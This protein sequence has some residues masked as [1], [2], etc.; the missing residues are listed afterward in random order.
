LE[1]LQDW[2]ERFLELG[3]QGLKYGRTSREKAL[4]KMVERQKRVIADQATPIAI[5]EEAKAYLKKKGS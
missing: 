3:L 2:R 4:E 5:L 1:Q